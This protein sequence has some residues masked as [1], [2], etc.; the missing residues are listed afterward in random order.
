MAPVDTGDNAE[1]VSFFTGWA[2]EDPTDNRIAATVP[3]TYR[4]ADLEITN[5]Q[6]PA[7][8]SSGQTDPRHLH[9]DQ[10]RQPRHAC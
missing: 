3:I 7:G 4:E 6:V 1:L 5:L 9:G 8:V 2:Y 10:R